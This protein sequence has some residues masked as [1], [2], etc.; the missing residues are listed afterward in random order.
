MRINGAQRCSISTLKHDEK[1]INKPRQ[2]SLEGASLNP[3]LQ[4]QLKL[5]PWLTQSPFVQIPA[6]SSHSL[7]STREK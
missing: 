6:T 3:A 7:I 1:I 5:P 2:A 4:R